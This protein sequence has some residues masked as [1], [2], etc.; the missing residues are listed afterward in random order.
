MAAQTRAARLLIAGIADQEAI[1]PLDSIS[2]PYPFE[3]VL[4][5]AGKI[6]TGKKGTS[7]DFKIQTAR[8]SVTA[9]SSEAT[10]NFTPVNP[11][12]NVTFSNKG[13][14]TSDLVHETDLEEA[15]GAQ[16][17][18]DIVENR[19]MWM[20][21][22]LGRARQ[23]ECYTGDGSTDS[24]FGANGII[25][26]DNQVRTTGSYGGQDV[27]VETALKGQVLSGG[28]HASFS[29]DPFPSLVATFIACMRGTDRGMG[30]YRP[31]HSFISPTGFGYLL[32]AANDLRR[33]VKHETDAQLGT[34]KITF[35]G[36]EILMDRFISTLKQYTINSRF[37][38]WHTP[39]GALTQVRKKEEL[40]PLSVS[41]L[42]FNYMKQ[43][44]RL[45]RAFAITTYA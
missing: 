27:A 13:Y 39:F 6:K 20:P 24:G 9:M 5:A 32:N 38:E 34:E 29:T 28:V 23:T 42:C 26:L 35:M 18:F 21:E 22:A 36:V 45:P 30:D 11:G 41:L 4:R 1:M 3:K 16:R 33:S 15:D 7:L 17:I 19:T 25:G 12:V 31:T 2:D 14:K 44:V 37:L 8:G 43:V 10:S 40:S